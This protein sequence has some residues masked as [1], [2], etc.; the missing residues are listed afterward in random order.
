MKIVKRLVVLSIVLMIF[1]SISYARP[2]GGSSRGGGS[3]GGGSGSHSSSGRGGRVHR[4][5]EDH[6]GQFVTFALFSSVIFIMGNTN[7]IMIRTKLIK[8][9]H[10]YKKVLKELS[11]SNPDYKLEKIQKDVSDTFYIMAK[12]WT[13]MNQ[14]IAIEYSTDKLYRNHNTKLQWMD[15]RN[16]RNILKNEK[17][18]SAKVFEMDNESNIWVVI[19]GS[20]IDYIEKEGQIIEGSKNIPSRYIEYW[21][22]N[23]VNGKWLLDEIK[24]VDELDEILQRVN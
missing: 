20:M 16:E 22:F 7:N 17:L 9:R 19:R 1:T 15:A 23:N 24:Q 2:G 6:K 11:K 5:K 12:A 4:T 10:H 13:E 14:D 21:K 8:R 3:S 18:I